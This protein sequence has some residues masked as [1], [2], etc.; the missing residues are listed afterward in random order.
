MQNAI[1]GALGE[2]RCAITLP[3]PS[4]ATPRSSRWTWFEG[5][6]QL[7]ADFLTMSTHAEQVWAR[8]ADH[9]INQTDPGQLRAAEVPRC[10][11]AATQPPTTTQA[12]GRW[13]VVTS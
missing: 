6:L 3:G 9:H 1:G 12:F 7:Q 10:G 11:H 8:H 13:W 4:G 2:L 5:W